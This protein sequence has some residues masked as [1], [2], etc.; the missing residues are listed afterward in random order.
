MLINKE[1]E[2]MIHDFITT[3]GISSKDCDI[4]EKVVN[5]E[6]DEI[7]NATTLTDVLDGFGD[8]IF[9]NEVLKIINK[10]YAC[11]SIDVVTELAIEKIN[12][13]LFKRKKEEATNNQL[14]EIL[15]CVCVSNMSKFDS[16]QL[17]ATITKRK[18]KDAGIK[19]YREQVGN[20]FVTRSAEKDNADFPE[21]KILKSATNYK[22]PCFKELILKN[23]WIC[24]EGG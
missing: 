8:V 9:A 10:N 22:A 16:S 2:N 1:N 19:T 24:A 5:E 18:Y 3:S 6:C 20:L 21:G 7:L 13:F 12:K 14:N 17:E 15:N 4:Q 23:N 11:S